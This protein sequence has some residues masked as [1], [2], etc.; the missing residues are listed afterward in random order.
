MKLWMGKLS[1]G[2]H[3]LKDVVYVCRPTLIFP[4]K[5]VNFHSMLILRK[6]LMPLRPVCAIPFL[7][8]IFF[9]KYG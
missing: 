8:L 7:C 4:N 1:L 5:Y 3:A 9:N 2:L 6:I